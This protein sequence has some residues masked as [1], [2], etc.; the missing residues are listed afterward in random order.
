MNNIIETE[1]VAATLLANGCTERQMG[2]LKN[3]L[4]VAEKEV[5]A[6]HMQ[7]VTMRAMAHCREDQSFCKFADAVL[8]SSYGL[9]NALRKQ[10]DEVAGLLGQRRKERLEQS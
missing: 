8:H 9:L 4:D 6:L 2:A 1:S 10:H 5:S 7:I 3:V